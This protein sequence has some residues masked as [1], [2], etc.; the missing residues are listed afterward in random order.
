VVLLSIIT[1][2][3][4][5]GALNKGSIS[6]AEGGMI[7][8][9]LDAGHGG[10]D[11]GVSGK[12]TGVKESDLNLMVVRKLEKYLLS[13]GFNVTLTRKTEA[14]LYGLPTGNKKK[15]DM[16][17]RKKII[18]EANADIVISVHMNYYSSSSRRGAQVF[19]KDGAEGGKQLAENLQKSFNEMDEASRNCQ[20]LTGDYYILNTSNCPAIIA[21]CGFLSNAEDEKLLVTEEYQDDIAYAMFKGIVDYL[22]MASIKFCD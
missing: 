5:L 20:I 21:E 8:I 19:Y 2:I 18:E 13:A 15:R 17:K 6:S 16:E 3:I 9:V 10:I 22:S 14:G 1:F 4:C 11:G 12:V 7:N